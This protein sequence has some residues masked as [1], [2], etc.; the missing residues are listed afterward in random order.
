MNITSRLLLITTLTTFALYAFPP[1]LTAKP[2]CPKTNTT[3]TQPTPSVT[4]T[5]AGATVTP[6]CAAMAAPCQTTCP[7]AQQL[8]AL[9]NEITALKRQIT[10]LRTD[11]KKVL[12]QLK[13]IKTTQPQAKKK[14]PPDTT[15]YDIPVGSSPTLGP[16]DAPVTI[17]E[18]VDLQCPFCAREYP[19]IKQI[20]ALYP[21][22][23]RF[24]FKHYP[25]SFHKKAPP[26][27]AAI[28]FALDTAGPEAFWK[29]H[30]LITA[31]PKN[32][33]TA[34][35]H[36]YAQSLNLDLD[37]FDKL[38]ADT[39]RINKLLA[40]DKALARKVN[41]RATPTVLINGLKLPRRTL[42]EYKKR[43]NQILNP[44]TQQK[45]PKP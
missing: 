11:M 1:A 24:V 14:R 8:D 26:A 25:L 4:V 33:E 21:D 38:T 42:P 19:K 9:S 45:T 7:A 3:A 2:C 34:H 18:F 36:S 37:Q 32:L 13:A 30:D 16:A 5:P 6:P 15:V 12:A 22:K 35:L 17:T 23:V 43:I 10:A 29:M 31:N 40:P 39:Q 28:Q 27:H 44:T 20:L 41:V